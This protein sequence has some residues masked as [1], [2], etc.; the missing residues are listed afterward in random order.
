MTTSSITVDY[1]IV[2]AGAAGMAFADTLLTETEA[3][4]AE[5]DARELAELDRYRR[6]LAPAMATLK[7]LLAASGAPRAA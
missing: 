7:N 5:T 3:T 6:N 2:G 4:L 1:L